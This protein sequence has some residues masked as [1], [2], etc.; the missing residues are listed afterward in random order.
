MAVSWF[1]AL[2]RV[3]V[4]LLLHDLQLSLSRVPFYGD[5]SAG[6]VGRGMDS[7]VLED[8][9]ASTAASEVFLHCSAKHCGGDRDLGVFEGNGMIPLKPVNFRRTS[10]P[11]S[12]AA[13]LEIIGEQETG[14]MR[15]VVKGFPFAKQMDGNGPVDGG[16]VTVCERDE[17]PRQRGGCPRR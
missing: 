7:D 13:I 9:I 1:G 5:G 6:V 8:E 2:M 12:P 4:I 16:V 3:E 15:L 11:T 10:S 17:F 14:G